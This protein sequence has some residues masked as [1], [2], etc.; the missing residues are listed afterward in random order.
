MSNELLD[1]S[2][3]VEK[4][5]TNVIMEEGV[6]VTNAASEVLKT[7]FDGLPNKSVP[8]LEVDMYNL[9]N[10]RSSVKESSVSDDFQFS[11]N[12]DDKS[13]ISDVSLEDDELNLDRQDEQFVIAAIDG[14]E[15]SVNIALDN[16]DSS[17]NSLSESKSQS[18]KKKIDKKST[19]NSII[20]T[21]D[22]EPKDLLVIYLRPRDNDWIMGED[23]EIEVPFTLTIRGLMKFIDQHRGIS[24]HR[25]IIKLKSGKAI[26]VDRYEWNL[27]RTGI[28]N[29]SFL[30]VEPTLSG[31]WLWNDISYYQ[32]K[33]LNEVM[34]LLDSC[35]G[36]NKV[37]LLSDVCKVIKCPPPIKS[38]LKVFLKKY[39]E[40]ISFITELYSD[41]IWI[42]KTAFEY[43][44]PKYINEPY[45][46][47]YPKTNLPDFPWE[48]YADIDGV[49]RIEIAIDP[50]TITYHLA[51]VAAEDLFR[52]DIFETTDVY[53][54]LFWN[55]NFIGRTAVKF[56]SLREPRWI[57]DRFKID[58]LAETDIAK[59]WLIVQLFE[60]PKTGLEKCIGCIDVTGSALKGLLCK[61]KS[62][63]ERFELL[64]NKP[65]RIHTEKDILMNGHKERDEGDEE[66]AEIEKNKKFKKSHRA[67]Q[68][69]G[70]LIMLGGPAGYEVGIVSARNLSMAGRRK[71]GDHMVV[72]LWVDND[73]GHTS[74][75]PE[76]LN[77]VWDSE[78]VHFNVPLSL[79]MEE[80]IL[81][82]QVWSMQVKDREKRAE[83]NGS[84]RL[85]GEEL[86]MLLTGT[87]PW[88]H[89][90]E[91]PLTVTPSFPKDAQQA[92]NIQG[93]LKVV[94]GQAGLLE[95]D[96]NR[97][98]LHIIS[99]TNLAVSGNIYCIITFNHE[100]VGK[101]MTSI[102]KGDPKTS[103]WTDQKFNLETDFGIDL[104]KSSHLWIEVYTASMIGTGEF[105]GQVVLR[106]GDVARLLCQNYA[107]VV[108]YDL[109]K[110]SDR[111]EKKQK[112]VQGTITLQGGPR[113]A[114]RITERTVVIKACKDISCVGSKQSDIPNPYCVVWWNGTRVGKTPVVNDTIHPFW[115][116]A[117]YHLDTSK[118]T[119]STSK[120]EIEVW[121]TDKRGVTQTFLGDVSLE[122]TALSAFL[123]S[124]QPVNKILNLTQKDSI[125]MRQRVPAVQ[126]E[127][128]F[129]TPGTVF[130]S[131]ILADIAY[132]EQQTVKAL[133]AIKNQEAEAAA[134]FAAQKNA[135]LIQESTFMV[136][137]LIDTEEDALQST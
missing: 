60:T 14:R 15:E 102:S 70:A 107:G 64:P 31:T 135:P 110:D 17:I 2:I 39:P 136:S 123:D 97:Y 30:Y 49:Q 73:I 50:Y 117:W 66:Q 65:E 57:G 48:Q 16:D 115:L 127:I 55:G 80:C 9:T 129:S 106:D 34:N 42:K 38:N 79:K 3:S 58:V 77:P 96:P 68:V 109:V 83:F 95:R 52:S 120:L 44:L 128:W 99:A 40:Y 56:K 19:N 108:T 61:G 10:E 54:K 22:E 88:A 75:A 37:M 126:G 46:L 8:D 82:L 36:N 93:S 18:R 47:G 76:S 33:L 35:S 45:Q 89:R 121:S 84:V 111:E 43:T 29:K 122:G 51:V 7:S 71:P 113:G 28:T 4:N 114:R 6:G 21:A 116:D 98:E 112:H 62:S 92:K 26:P 101:T 27:K 94:G 41:R 63:T 1:D 78:F 119:V 137:P 20:T 103:Q 87:D 11:G 105:L 53:C 5:P 67:V 132:E 85:T 59:C 69:S 118:Q 131:E 134:K 124:Y 23:W 130:A 104:A 24:E 12:V 125:P 81:E 25:I 86:K 13:L 91:K 133:E 32:N 90:I 72:V 100:L 74:V